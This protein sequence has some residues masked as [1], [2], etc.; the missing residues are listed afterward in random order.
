VSRRAALLLPALTLTAVLTGCAGQDTASGE[1]TSA[2]TGAASTAPSAAPSASPSAAASPS[3][4]PEPSPTPTARV[5][6]VTVAGGAVSGVEPRVEVGLGEQVVL[7]VRS[8]VAEEVHVH[9]YDLFVDVPA[10]GAA[11]LPF[12]AD[13]PGGFEVELEGSHQLLFQL[14]VA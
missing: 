8:D 6:D 10:G 2:A 5:I 1:A 12:T 4:T 7:R 11:E 13:I 14:R 9:G 3:A